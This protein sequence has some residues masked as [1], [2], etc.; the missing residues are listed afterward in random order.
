MAACNPIPA[1]SK[2]F[3]IPDNRR[4]LVS[5]AL[6]RTAKEMIMK[7]IFSMVVLTLLMLSFNEPK[8]PPIEENYPA[9][10]FRSP[11]SHGI[12]LSGTFGELR[13]NHFHAGIDIKSS[14]GV[15]GDPILSAALGYI[16]R[17]SVDASG[18]GNTLYV[19]HPIGYTT[20]YAHL[21]RF[22]PEIAAYV[23]EQQYAQQ[24]FEV[25]LLPNPDKFPVQQGQ[26]IGIMGNTGSSQG[27]HLHFEI[28]ETHFQN[29]V[30]PLLFGFKVQDRIAPK[31]HAL[32][33]YSL[34][35]NRKEAS[36][37]THVLFKSAGGA[38]RIKG[39]TLVLQSE[40]SGFS[41]KVFDHFDRVS[42]W[43]GIYALEMF[44]DD[45]LVYKFDLECFALEETR[46]L[47]AHCDYR[48][49]VANNSYYNRCFTLPGNRLS[50]YRQLQNS[51]VI[52]LEEGRS[53]EISMVACDLA[54]NK[55]ELRFWV[56]RGGQLPSP[57]TPLSYN[58]V[59]PYD[60][61][62]VI[63]PEG[64]Y[65]HMPVGTLYE[66]LYL[67]YKASPER[68]AGCY[69]AVHHLHDSRTPVHDYFDIGISPSRP[70]PDHLKAKSFIAYC[71]GSGVWNCG[72]EWKDSLL[73]AQVRALGDY[74]I[75]TDVVRPSIKPIAFNYDMKSYTR[76]KFL[77]GDNV[78]S[79]GKGKELSYNAW[80]DDQWILMEYDKKSRVIS[81]RFDERV[82]KGEHRFR[83]V[84]ADAVGNEAVFEKKFVR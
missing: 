24:S 23:E 84:V 25:D 19:N 43:N 65:L 29:P 80:I 50:I 13:P 62:N 3:S 47:N 14:K 37:K 38:Y 42:N 8:D 34:D 71:S 82:G 67:S 45:S 30:N 4:A 16:S 77:I 55:S 75:M 31:M 53:S 2:D 69:S 22:S 15:A 18:Y 32:R 7:R 57:S 35:E 9:D 10:Y 48:E 59:L 73:F 44:Q 6:S 40:Q 41:L 52:R 12:L 61:G 63:R 58:Y 27:V 79:M 1:K 39:D 46:Y 20:V 64:L 49:R 54:G 70:I 60:E 26:Q 66:D 72:G 28:R 21:D 11:V 68:S 5:I 36:A 33:V 74:C 83:L 81:Y 17:I 56:K 76:M 78:S 51:G